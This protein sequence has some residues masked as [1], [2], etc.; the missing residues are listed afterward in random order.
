MPIPTYRQML[1]MA[2]RRLSKRIGATEKE[3]TRIYAQARRDIRDELSKA[4]ERY[5]VNGELT[6]AEMTKYNRLTNLEKSLTSKLNVADNEAISTTHRLTREQ[7]QEA[8]FNRAW[9]IDNELTA[10][11]TWGRLSAD[12]VREAVEN[13]LHRIAD[14]RLRSGSRERIRATIASGLTRG[15][16][17]AQMSREIRDVINGSRHDAVR[18]ARTEG[19]RAQAMGS[20][21]AHQRAEELG[22][23]GNEYWMATLDGRTRDRHGQL[24]GK[25]KDKER[26]GWRIPG[27][28]NYTPGPL[29]SGI[30]SFDISCRC[31][32]EYRI[33]DEAPEVRRIRGEGVVDYRTYEEWKAPT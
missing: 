24:D 4:Y 2:E 25:P 15:D 5:A 1:A 32:V 7:Y 29:Q 21:R 6:R 10:Q 19:Q 22:V 16:S 8:F 33:N 14:R 3:I 9:A 26:G 12:A 23:E 11:L 31:A 18:I 27:T 13:P 17:F 28:N 20:Q 30:P